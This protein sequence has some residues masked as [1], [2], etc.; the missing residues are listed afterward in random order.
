MSVA[1]QC[2]PP[3]GYSVCQYGV[4]E[5]ETIN[6]ACAPGY[7]FNAVDYA[8]E[9]QAT[10]IV[11]NCYQGFYFSTTTPCGTNLATASNI[12]SNACLGRSSCSISSTPAQWGGET[13]ADVA[14]ARVQEGSGRGTYMYPFRVRIRRADSRWPSRSPLP[15]RRRPVL[16]TGEE[17]DGGAALRAD[18]SDSGS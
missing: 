5:T 8:Y 13:T 10:Q 6:F 14:A 15:D 11:G 17:H 7:S 4:P 12:V 9:G 18:V 16:W 2:G 3:G 1:V